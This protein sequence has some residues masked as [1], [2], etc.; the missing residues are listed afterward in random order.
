MQTILLTAGLHWFLCSNIQLTP[1]GQL[2]L[3]PKVESL[4]WTLSVHLLTFN[5]DNNSKRKFTVR[6]GNSHHTSSHV[7]QLAHTLSSQWCLLHTTPPHFTFSFS[8]Y[9]L[10]SSLWRLSRLLKCVTGCVCLLDCGRCILTSL[11]SMVQEGCHDHTGV[12]LSLVLF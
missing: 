3:K 10:F 2:C 1:P 5:A 9:A 12:A 11:V 4:L 6:G 8:A 7:L